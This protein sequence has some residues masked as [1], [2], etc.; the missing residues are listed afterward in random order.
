MAESVRLLVRE[1]LQDQDLHA[2]LPSFWARSAETRAPSWN[3]ICSVIEASKWPGQGLPL[4][5]LERAQ[6][7]NAV[8][9]SRR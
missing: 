4:P 8:H 1:I 7:R 9:H 6:D 2:R 5:R 3:E